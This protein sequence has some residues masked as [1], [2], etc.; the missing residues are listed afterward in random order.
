MIGKSAWSDSHILVESSEQVTTEDWRV[1]NVVDSMQS[2][3][4]WS[5]NKCCEVIGTKLA[6]YLLGFWSSLYNWC[7]GNQLLH[8]HQ[9]LVVCIIPSPPG[10]TTVCTFG[11]VTT[12]NCFL[13][14]P[15]SLCLPNVYRDSYK[16]IGSVNSNGQEKHNCCT[17]IYNITPSSGGQC[18]KNKGWYH[19]SYWEHLHQ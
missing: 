5:E 10:F 2:W 4:V 1:I 14:K 12:L 11:L 8:T 19:L 7:Q 15:Y 13:T 17:I 18:S 9:R 3:V 16:A 6:S